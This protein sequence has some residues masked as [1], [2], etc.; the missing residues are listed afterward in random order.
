MRTGWMNPPAELPTVSNLGGNPGLDFT[1]WSSLESH[2]CISI[3]HFSLNNKSV[4]YISTEKI[5]SASC[6]F[7]D[8]FK[9]YNHVICE[10]RILQYSLQYQYRSPLAFKST[11]LKEYSFSGIW[12]VYFNKAFTLFDMYI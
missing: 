11:T 6:I 12:F 1:F 9:C 7:Y 2:G 5:L 8:L 10:S 3:N 4:H